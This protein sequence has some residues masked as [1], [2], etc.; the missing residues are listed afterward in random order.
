MESDSAWDDDIANLDFSVK[1]EDLSNQEETSEVIDAGD[2]YGEEDSIEAIAGIETSN[3]SPPE[4]AAA[5]EQA[6]PATAPPIPD[7]GLPEGWTMD[8]WKWYGQ[9]WLDKNK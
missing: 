3:Q 4:A 8:Q 5:M 2:L 7:S 1:D 6:A 9:E